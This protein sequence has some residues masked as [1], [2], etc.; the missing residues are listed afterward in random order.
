MKPLALVI[1]ND[2]GTRKLL[3]VLLSRFGLAVDVVPTGSDALLLLEQV[4]YDLVFVDLMLAATSGEDV[5]AWIDE[6]RPSMLERCIVLS[7]A[8]PVQLERIRERWPAVRTIRK[9]FELSEIVKAAQATASKS[10]HRTGSLTE[11]F[12]RRSVAAGAKAGVVLRKME[13][14]L[15]PVLWFGYTPGTVEAYGAIAVEA[16]LPI[17]VAARQA[18][19]VWLASLAAAA[20]DYPQ[21]VADSEKFE[22]RALAA[23]PVMHDGG[24]VGVAGWSFREARLFHEPEREAFLSIAGSFEDLFTHQGPSAAGSPA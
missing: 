23:V 1:E 6:H 16:A 13:N 12:T 20:S 10:A 19:P 8:A 22:S 18:R 3:D 21:L 14:T 4:A 11:E 5:L 7:S 15:V 2:R 9:P 24:A 17:S